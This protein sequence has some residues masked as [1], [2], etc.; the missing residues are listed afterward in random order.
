MSMIPTSITYATKWSSCPSSHGTPLVSACWTSIVVTVGRRE[1]FADAGYRVFGVDEDARSVEKARAYIHDRQASADFD[2][3]DVNHWH[4]PRTDWNVIYSSLWMY[5]CTPDRQGRKE[6]LQQISGWLARDGLLVISVFPRRR[7][8]LGQA[9]PSHRAGHR[10]RIV[11]RAQPR[12]G[13]SI[14]HPPVLA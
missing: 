4:P 10:F 5:S 1:F 9:P 13:R 12:A 11:Q 3:A 2:T 7:E 6:W 8:G 14:S